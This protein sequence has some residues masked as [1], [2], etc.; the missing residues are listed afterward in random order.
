MFQKLGAALTKVT[1]ARK[2]MA[3]LADMM[4]GMIE[5]AQTAGMWKLCV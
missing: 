5:S 1:R 2:K 4:K 3:A